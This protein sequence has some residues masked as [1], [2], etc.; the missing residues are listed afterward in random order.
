MILLSYTNSAVQ[1]HLRFLNMEGQRWY[2]FCSTCFSGRW[3][4]TGLH[5]HLHLHHPDC[6]QSVRDILLFVVRKRCVL[7]KKQKKRRYWIWKLKICCFSLTFH[8]RPN[9]L[10][11]LY[12]ST[13]SL[14]YDQKKSIWSRRDYE[15]CRCLN[16]SKCDCL[17]QIAL[18]DIWR[19]IKAFTP[20]K[21]SLLKYFHVFPIN[22]TYCKKNQMK[23]A[24]NLFT[25]CEL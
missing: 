7:K 24:V 8:V 15:L 6:C 5:L 10:L 22:L 20:Q 1:E 25:I 4:W 21:L 11:Q 16:I 13:F 12:C 14:K 2:M 18:N 9:H 3:N 23:T 17:L 19:E